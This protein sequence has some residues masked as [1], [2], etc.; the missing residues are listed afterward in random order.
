LLRGMIAVSLS[1]RHCTS[2]RYCRK[3]KRNFGTVITSY[4]WI[5]RSTS[6]LDVYTGRM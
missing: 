4:H 6:K 2:S 3:G 5:K 1:Y